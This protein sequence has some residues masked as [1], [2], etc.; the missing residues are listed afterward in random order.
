MIQ[1]IKGLSVL[2]MVALGVLVIMGVLFLVNSEP[3]RVERTEDV[4]LGG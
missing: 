1:K 2:Q 3:F 4:E